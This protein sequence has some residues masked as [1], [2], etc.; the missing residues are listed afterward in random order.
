M[1]WL[2]NMAEIR[3]IT[4]RLTWA[5]I[6]LAVMAPSQLAAC[7]CLVALPVCQ[8]VASSTIVFIGLAKSVD[9]PF[10]DPNRRAEQKDIAEEVERLLRD[11]STDVL[12]RL[13][14]AY[15]RMLGDQNDS[16]KRELSKATSSSEAKA[17]FDSIVSQGRRARFATR[18]IFWE[19]KDD[20][21][22]GV[23]G[24]DPDPEE[25]GI[26]R[27]L[28]IWTGLDDCGVDFQVGETYLVYAGEDEQTGRFQ[29]S[30]C[31]RTKRLTDAG[32]D[33]PYLQFFRRN[34]K[35][36][37]RIEG[38]VLTLGAKASASRG[39][40][41]PSAGGLI[42]GLNGEGLTRYATA[43]EAGRFVFDGLPGGEYTLSAYPDEFPM[44]KTVLAGPQTVK[45]PEKG[46]ATGL[47][48]PLLKR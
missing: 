48:L 40:T 5:A 46:C 17:A 24:L 32:T 30:A 10:L 29:T 4:S 41:A 19:A 11:E 38:S 39:V 42:V 35:L 31:S 23:P 8:E 15:L 47:M 14:A 28:T 7:K 20:D 2:L 6:F 12:D 13:K 1:I 16:M 26:E 44:T 9:P 36:S 45:V 3:S 34:G 21:K 25:P 37:S 18:T 22:T 33:L 27:D 43:D